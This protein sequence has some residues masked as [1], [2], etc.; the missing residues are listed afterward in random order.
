[1]SLE[2]NQRAWANMMNN[3]PVKPPTNAASYKA[4]TAKYKAPR[5]KTPEDN[6][7][8]ESDYENIEKSKRSY[9]RYREKMGLSPRA[10]KTPEKKERRGRKRSKSPTKKRHY[11]N[12]SYTNEFGRHIP[13]AKYIRS[14]SRVKRKVRSQS[15]AR[16]TVKN[17][18]I[19][20]EFGRNYHYERPK[21]VRGTKYFDE[22]TKEYKRPMH[23]FDETTRTYV[24][25]E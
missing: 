21:R 16:Y 11:R 7:L 6:S 20:N 2:Q 5:P 25:M 4:K 9:D 10:N 22:K 23:V 19:V 15:P 12:R 14:A 1:M 24:P 17:G 18:Q 13:R 3:S 8:R